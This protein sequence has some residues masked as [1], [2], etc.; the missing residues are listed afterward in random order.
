MTVTAE[1]AVSA[2]QKSQKFTYRVRMRDDKIETG[3]ATHTSR[4]G[5]IASLKRNQDIQTILY[6]FNPTAPGAGA[7]SRPKNPSLV[8]SSRQLEFCLINGLDKR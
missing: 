4:D 3:E 1:A 8:A 2:A 5:V 7:K 6:V